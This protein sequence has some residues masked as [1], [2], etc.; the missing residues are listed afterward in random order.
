MSQRS[1]QLPPATSV[2]GR[3]GE[4][5]LEAEGLG[6]ELRRLDVVAVDSGAG[7][8]IGLALGVGR[9]GRT[10]HLDRHGR[11]VGL[12]VPHERPASRIWAS[13]SLPGSAEAA[14]AAGDAIAPDAPGVALD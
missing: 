8:L 5:G 3:A 6:D 7:G 10:G 4:A 2:E 11:V 13:S 12:V 14:A 9:A 1:P